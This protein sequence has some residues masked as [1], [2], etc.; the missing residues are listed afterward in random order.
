MSDRADPEID[1]MRRLLAPFLVGCLALGC[2]AASGEVQSEGCAGDDA[3]CAP[4]GGI[5]VELAPADSFS[6]VME[7]DACALVSKAVVARALELNCAVTMRICPDLVR[8]HSGTACLLYDSDRL[9]ECAAD[10]ASFH[11]CGPLVALPCAPL[12]LAGTAPAGCA[13]APE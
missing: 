9:A 8:V 10:L 3:G 4:E 5:D 13:S 11:A 2:T 12:D 6:R 1:R 7:A